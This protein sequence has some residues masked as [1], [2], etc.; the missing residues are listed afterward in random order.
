MPDGRFRLD[1][2][3]AREIAARRGTPLHVIDE[4]T[5]RARLVAAREAWR[6]VEPRGSLSYASKANPLPA[7]TRIASLEGYC[8]DVASEGELRAALYGGTPPERIHVHGNAKTDSL[9]GLCDSVRVG[10]VVVDHVGELR[11]LP[12]G[13][14]VML[15]LAPGVD[16]RTDAKISTGQLDTKFGFAMADGQALDAVREALRLGHRLEGFHCHVGSQ[17]KDPEVQALAGE[18]LARFAVTVLE[19]TGFRTERINVGGGRAARYVD[20]EP[21]DLDAYNVAIS[22]RMREV[23]TP[24]GLDPVLEQEP[25]RSLIAEAG[26][27]LYSVMAIK[28]VPLPEGPKRYAAVD[29]G[30]SDNLRPALYGAR[31]DVSRVGGWE[32][33]TDGPGAASGA[34][35]ATFTVSGAH[36]ETDTLFPDVELPSDLAPGDLLQV[37]TT[38]AYHSA[39][40]SN[41]NRFL[42]APTLLRR[43]DGTFDEIQ[44]RERWEELCA[45]DVILPDL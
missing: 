37:L 42:R 31:Y 13:V 4:A 34:Y 28:T 40:A 16:P 14:P 30:L 18:I 22:R 1:A 36:C 32:Y 24:A 11:R 15:R 29:G 45:R 38:G 21:V 44:R 7:L 10:T 2:T 43:L 5:F 6:R 19:E 26:V 35:P 25:G 33:V 8:V 12:A 23:L 41:Y 20:E 17:T 27:T 3:D 9:L 39:M